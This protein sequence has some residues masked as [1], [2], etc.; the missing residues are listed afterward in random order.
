MVMIII[1]NC[2][3]RGRWAT[4]FVFMPL[5]VSGM[6]CVEGLLFLV[7]LFVDAGVTGPDC[8]MAAAVWKVLKGR[9]EVWA[10]AFQP[11]FLGSSKLEWILM[12]IFLV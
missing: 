5:G 2:H 1:E 7:I 12:N 9:T 11:A 3:H 10:L 4:H 6:F 8:T